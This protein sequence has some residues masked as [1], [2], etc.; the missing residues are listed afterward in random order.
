MKKITVVGAGKIGSTIAALLGAS[1]DYSVTVVDTSQGALDGVNGGPRVNLQALD[2][3]DPVALRSALKGQFAVL[4]AAPFHLTT[5]IAEAAVAEKVHYLD[6]TED[7]ASTR[8]VKLSR[9]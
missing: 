8:R 5:A 3:T 7:V 6:L 9:R 1:D 4:S 2:V